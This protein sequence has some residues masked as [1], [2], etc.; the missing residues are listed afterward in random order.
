LLEAAPLTFLGRYSYGMYLI[1]AVI[2]W[3]LRNTYLP[4]WKPA[5]GL[6]WALPLSGI[7]GIAISLALAIAMFHLIEQP[8]LRLK[9]YFVP[10]TAPRE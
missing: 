7:L 4:K 3:E 1:H 6:N 2:F 8:L 10:K 5:I 9:R